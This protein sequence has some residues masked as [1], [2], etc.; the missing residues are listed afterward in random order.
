MTPQ[1]Q[2]LMRY[3]LKDFMCHRSDVEEIEQD[4][5]QQEEDDSYRKL[6]HKVGAN[7]EL[8]NPFELNC[9]DD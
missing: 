6:E 9:L 1:F 2:A 8:L 3:V 4:L 7:E 5:R